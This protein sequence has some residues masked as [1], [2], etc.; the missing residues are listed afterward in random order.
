M[1]TEL[2]KEQL[3]AVRCAM[4]DLI[5]VWQTCVRDGAPPSYHDWKAHVQSIYDLADAFDL[6]SDVPEELE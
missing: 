5:G 4:A 1:T 2:T 3:T 6:H